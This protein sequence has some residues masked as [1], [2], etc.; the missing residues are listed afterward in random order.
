MKCCEYD[1]KLVTENKS[2]YCCILTLSIIKKKFDIVIDFNWLG[3]TQCRPCVI[4]I[5]LVLYK[6]VMFYSTSAKGFIASL[7]FLCNLPKV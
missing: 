2:A 6:S 5:F 1:A 3:Q 7:H 4:N